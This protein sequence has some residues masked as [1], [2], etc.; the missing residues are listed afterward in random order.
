MPSRDMSEVNFLDLSGLWCL[1]DAV[2]GGRIVASS[3]RVDRLLELTGTGDLLGPARTGGRQDHEH[4][5]Q[6]LMGVQE[7]FE[8]DPQWLWAV[9]RFVAGALV[10]TEPVDDIVLIASELATNVVRH[11]RTEFTV[12]VI[13]ED[14]RVRLEVA[15]GSSV[16]PALN[17]LTEDQ[18]GWRL[19]QVVAHDWGIEATD[20][21]K[22]AW[23]E[24]LTE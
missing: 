20:D 6:I 8:P 18:R 19:I 13:K 11:A 12:K 7:S 17:E 22:V 21:G 14:D 3:P 15:D 5:G 24:F 4:A 2:Q 1:L 9:R 16:V 23:V 10:G